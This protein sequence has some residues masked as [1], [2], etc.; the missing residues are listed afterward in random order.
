MPENNIVP[1]KSAAQFERAMIRLAAK[2]PPNNNFVCSYE[3]FVEGK[4]FNPESGR[5]A[6][7]NFVQSGA[8]LEKSYFDYGRFCFFMPNSV[9]PMFEDILT[10][11][12]AKLAVHFVVENNRPARD[13][14]EAQFKIAFKTAL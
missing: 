6:M 12:N 1:S 7:I 11:T 9:L 14:S 5:S 13:Q 2:F 3:V 10:G 4:F 8:Q